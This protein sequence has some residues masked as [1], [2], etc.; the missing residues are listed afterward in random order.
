MRPKLCRIF[1]F[2]EQ[3]HHHKTPETIQT[4]LTHMNKK[5]GFTS[6]G[7]VLACF[8]SAAFA[9]APVARWNLGEQDPAAAAGNPG[10]P[11]TLDV[12][13]TN[14]L[15]ASGAPV[16]SGTAA[17]G[18]A[19]SMSFDGASFYQGSVVGNG[20]GLDV[21][22]ASMDFNNFSL[23]CDVYMTAPGAVGFSFPVSIGR[24]GAGIAIVEI[25]GK[26]HLI[27][28]G[29][30]AS[31]A[32]PDVALNTWTHLDLVRKNF[33]S[34]V[35]TR[36]FLD[37][38]A[39][40]AV[41]LGGTPVTPTDFLTIG[42]NELG[43]AVPGLVEGYFQGLVD[44]VVITNLSIAAP[45][46]LTGL[47]LSP[48]TIYTGNSIILAAD[49]AAGDS[50]GLTFLWRKDGV[51]IT[52]SGAQAG[53]TLPNVTVAN[54]GDYDVV[55]TNNFGAV[56]SAV[57]TV[58]VLDA[59]YSGG[60]DVV[61]FRM[62]DDDSGA[63]AGNPGNAVTR[64]GLGT[65]DL[66]AVGAPMYSSDV[67][68]GG[69]TFSTS[70]DGAS[71]YYQSLSLTDLYQ[72]LDFNNFGISLDVKVNASG[73][74]GFSFPI[75]MGGQN[76][77]GFA[78][79]EIAGRWHIIHQTVQASGPGPA[80]ALGQWT[81]LE[82][83]RRQFGA[84]VRSRLFVNGVD[85]GVEITSSPNLPIH[86][87]LT[88]AANP[89]AD[90]LSVEGPFNGLVDNMVIHDYSVGAKPT[91][92][93]EIDAEPGTILLEGESLTLAAVA[94]GGSPLTFNWRRN[95]TVFA[96]TI[97][98]A[99]GVGST[100]LANVTLGD[101]GNYDVIV[102]N[103]LGSATSPA[104][105]VT[106]LPAGSTR[107]VPTVK[108]RL[109]EDDP[110][111]MAG[112]AGNITT[113]PAAGSLE[114]TASGSPLYSA[115]GPVGGS[116]LSMSFD[117]ASFYE[118]TGEAW[119]AFYSTFDF[120][121]FSASC[122]VYMTAPGASGFSF[123]F[124]I[125]GRFTGLAAVE[126]GGKWQAIHHSAAYSSVGPDVV[127]NAWTH[128]ELRRMNFGS[129][130]QTRLLI[131]GE[132]L[133]ITITGNPIAPANGLL[134]GANRVGAPE[135]YFNGQI[136]NFQMFSYTTPAGI[137]SVAFKDGQVEV[138]SQGFPGATYTLWRTPTLDVQ[139][140]TQVTSGVADANG[141]LTLTDPAPPSG[142]AF[143]R[144]SAP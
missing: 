115:N 144:T 45:P 23:S 20:A 111:A 57:V 125:G 95:G 38:S 63:A 19:L 68:A 134:I 48:G 130:I 76:G 97:A 137:L 101:A 59:S 28:Q 121:H 70:F 39:T 113:K 127:L 64:D 13:G 78:I 110:N 140:W 142:G 93:S 106:V 88:I 141:H 18:S 34:G 131:N 47:T 54:S 29:V 66:T 72:R 102:S 83:Q 122:D 27:H 7:F 25:S 9:A 36:L 138:D 100:T 31:G 67:P 2:A 30:A 60:A 74:S 91:I 124:S 108:Y 52:N 94:Q 11:L 119:T 90:E 98:A 86:P 79:V 80:V 126:I 10:N 55:L 120:N 41:T 43:N 50:A 22:Y 6:A 81:H 136:D 143:Y 42:A 117:G 4:Q 129:G 109:G 56:T 8:G 85:A 58:T 116:T 105:K 14:H 87:N 46:T 49:G 128:L 99:G 33:G 53:V 17:A 37:G 84:A 51:A 89:L 12:V 24:N 104:V 82:L 71:S 77:G 123:P 1:P 135:G 40:A 26:W 3:A 132:D 112:S 5:L 21:L 118:G 35:E 73:A 44:N 16:Y 15:A 69:G 107:P 103:L 92:I 61:R 133:A 114:L 32:G 75:S 139:S 96:S 62:G 65:N